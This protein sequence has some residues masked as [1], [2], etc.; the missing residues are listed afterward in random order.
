[1]I[2][3]TDFSLGYEQQ[4]AYCIVLIPAA[5]AHGGSVKT[6]KTAHGGS[7]ETFKTAH[8]G[9]VETFNTQARTSYGLYVCIL[10]WRLCQRLYMTIVKG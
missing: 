9:S 7:V 5:T 4:L 8:G 10:S 3:L 1:M 2:Y 6:F